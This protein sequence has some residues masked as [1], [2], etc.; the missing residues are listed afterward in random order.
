VKNE[1]PFWCLCHVVKGR[2]ELVSRVYGKCFETHRQSAIFIS[3]IARFRKVASV[4]KTTVVESH[5]L[6]RSVSLLVDGI[7][8]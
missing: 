2:R 1:H 8:D 6:L 3:I 4:E 7:D 5:K